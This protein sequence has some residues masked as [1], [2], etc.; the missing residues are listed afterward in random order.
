MEPSEESM[1]RSKL[2]SL[3]KNLPTSSSSDSGSGQEQE[4]PASGA[5]TRPKRLPSRR[6]YW[7]GEAKDVFWDLVRKLNKY[8]RD[9]ELDKSPIQLDVAEEATRR[10]WELEYGQATD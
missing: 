9:H 3:A 8:D 2:S 1:W 4:Q 5:T 10:W 7:P 6:R